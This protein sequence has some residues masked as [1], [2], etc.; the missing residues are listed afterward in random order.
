MNFDRY[1]YS[2]QEGLDA[3]WREREQL[4]ANR[5]AAE[6]RRVLR[7]TE[8]EDRHQGTDAGTHHAATPVVLDGL[9]PD[10]WPAPAPALQTGCP[11]GCQQAAEDESPL[12][13]LGRQALDPWE[14]RQASYAAT[15]R[16]LHGQAGPALD[17]EAALKL[18]ADMRVKFT[19]IGDD[20]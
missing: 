12:A 19:S 4:R 11:C 13:I 2:R 7:E 8:P 3:A 16:T 17:G 18:L 14:A 6:R 10:H 9:P 20:E 5:E 15:R 1:G